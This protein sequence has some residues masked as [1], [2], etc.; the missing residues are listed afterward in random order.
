MHIGPI[1][2]GSTAFTAQMVVSQERGELGDNLVYALPREISRGDVTVVVQP[3]QIRYLLPKLEWSR[4]SA[5]KSAS[6]QPTSDILGNRARDYLDSLVAELRTRDAK[7]VAVFFVEEALSRRSNPQKLTD[8]LL[9][10]FDSV[11]YFF[12]A[13]SQQFIVPSAISQRVKV[14]A[15]PK[16]WDSRV[17]TFVKNENLSQQFDYSQ[18]LK[19]WSATGSRTRLLSVPF[20]ESDRGTQRLFYRILETVGV[21][22]N[23]GDPVAASINVTPTRFEMLAIGLYKF[24][25]YPW[26]RNGL[27]PGSRA[28]R[29]FATFSRFA[30]RVATILRSPRWSISSRDRS[31]IID[32]YAI[33]NRRFAELLGERAQSSEWQQWFRDA[34]DKN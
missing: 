33:A 8:E 17:S 12:V 5:E 11:D 2:T 3:E 6:V 20:L 9:S 32:H 22:A 7:E 34:H 25:T 23:L 21:H 30:A 24:V 13:R 27:T 1:K 15:Y 4:Q 14:V 10:R 31:A 28:R 19:R 16:V 29:A 18:L 26:S